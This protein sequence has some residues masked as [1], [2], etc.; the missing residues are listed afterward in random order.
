MFI[1]LRK[2]APIILFVY[3]RVNKLKK[4]IESLRK[5]KLSVFSEIY[6]FSDGYKNLQDK[7]D[8]LEV[9]KFLKKLNGFKKVKI[10]YRRQN[11]GLAKNIINGTGKILKIKK[12][13][14]ILED[15][16]IVSP[17][18][19]YFMNFCLDKFKDEKKIWHINA[20]NYKIKELPCSDI[21]YWRGMHCWGWATW[22][23][24]WINFNKNPSQLIKSF[25]NKAIKQFN[26]DGYYNFWNQVLRNHQKKLNT[27]AIFWYATI[28]FNNGLC[29]SPRE[30]LASNI[31]YDSK[32]TNA[33]KSSFFNQKFTLGSFQTKKIF[34]FQKTIIE[35]SFIYSKIKKFLLKKKIK[36]LFLKYFM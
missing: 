18:F 1:N 22:H 10:I 26:Y 11:F 33:L 2:C 21:F 34:T 8:V 23:D 32:A 13:G 24:R 5:N 15:D 6:I 27:W 9:R 4:V 31:G 7:K 19:L 3:R 30:S 17:N 35:N 25:D 28:F 16:I 20:W 36:Y 12:M 14:I 29:L